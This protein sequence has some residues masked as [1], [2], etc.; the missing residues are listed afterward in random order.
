MRIIISDIIK[1][2]RKKMGINQETLAK[3]FGI[4]IQA[5]SK[6]EKGLS[7]PDIS[8]LPGLAEFF[9]VTIDY[10]LT[11]K[12]V[13]INK[14]E[15]EESEVLPSAVYAVGG[16]GEIREK[17]P[18]VDSL[19][20]V[21]IY[22]GH[23][24]EA[25][26][27]IDDTDKI[28]LKV[29]SGVWNIDI[30]CAASLSFDFFKGNVNVNGGNVSINGEIVGNVSA[31][32]SNLSCC[33]HIDGSVSLRDSNASFDSDISGDVNVMNG[34]IAAG[35]IGGNLLFQNGNVTVSGDVNGDVAVNNGNL[36]CEGDINGDFEAADGDVTVEGDVAGDIDVHYGNVICEGD[37]AG[38]IEVTDGSITCEGD[39][40]GDVSVTNGSF[41]SSGD[42]CG[43]FDENIEDEDEDETDG[44]GAETESYNKRHTSEAVKN[45]PAS[46]I[47]HSFSFVKDNSDENTAGFI[48][49]RDDSGK[50]CVIVE[51]LPDPI[52][53]Y[54]VFA[55]PENGINIIYQHSSVKNTAVFLLLGEGEYY[56]FLKDRDRSFS[57]DAVDFEETE[58]GYV[59]YHE[60][61]D[62]SSVTV[63]Y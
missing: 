44:D 63:R 7:C 17:C 21:E 58:E 37:I 40:A 8:L 53:A 59:F 11:G 61:C 55:S 57:I 19:Y 36:I 51:R 23:I 38:D 34:S 2:Q 26:N 31:E 16:D 22:N 28:E 5:V 47:K 54:D 4:S 10:L 45:A 48:L 30:N 39:V 42:V 9:G 49:K 50:C 24:I 25:S 56:L 20:I 43:D 52:V 46:A 35:D 60:G 41:T 1:E 33:D 6:W 32:G 13:V 3:Q 29:P 18:K 62:S 27:K 14:P 15:D 12:N